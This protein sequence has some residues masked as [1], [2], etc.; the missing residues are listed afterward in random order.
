MARRINIWLWRYRWFAVAVCLAGALGITLAQLRPA[1]PVTTPTVVASAALAAGQ[2]I[3]AT[4]VE[5]VELSTTFAQALSLDAA[6]GRRLAIGVP[7]GTPLI[8]PM[9]IGP[10]LAHSAPPG[11]VVVTVALADLA[12][13]DL[14]QAGDRLDLYATAAWGDT[15]QAHR[16]ATRAVV[17][18]YA[19]P[20]QDE[21]WWATGTDSGA[22]IIVAVPSEAAST[23]AGA[24][25][26]GP[27]R[28][29]FSV[30][31]DAAPKP[32]DAATTA[33]P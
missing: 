23:M 19:P 27:F 15:P 8:E 11:H 1:P 17:L 5:I 10:G 31:T 32:A 24:A 21:S 3:S 20:S 18:A 2:V 33:W 30:V 4:D 13:A 16:V 9:V 28:A 22:T 25:G 7:P 14:V 26:S 29:T 12:F 6:I